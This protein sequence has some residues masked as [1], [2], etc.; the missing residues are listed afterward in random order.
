MRLLVLNDADA[1]V[2][3]GSGRVSVLWCCLLSLAG[4]GGKG[5]IPDV[6][7][8]RVILGLGGWCG[9]LLFTAGV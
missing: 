4:G 1:G 7:G 8:R 5:K 2:G 9:T 6:Q 3:G